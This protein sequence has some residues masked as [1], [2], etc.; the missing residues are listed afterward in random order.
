MIACSK[1]KTL[2]PGRDIRNERRVLVV[3]VIMLLRKKIGTVFQSFC[4]AANLEIDGKVE[5][6]ETYLGLLLKEVHLEDYN[7]NG[8]SF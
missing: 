6:R 3:L 7:G 5:L 4:A 1:Y 2:F 8:S